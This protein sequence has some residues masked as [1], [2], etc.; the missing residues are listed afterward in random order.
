MLQ[1]ARREKR[2]R[3]PHTRVRLEIKYVRQKAA[4]PNRELDTHQDCHTHPGRDTHSS[5]SEFMVGSE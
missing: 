2:Y 4:I 3:V 1:Q 5:C